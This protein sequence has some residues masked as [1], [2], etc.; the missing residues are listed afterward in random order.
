MRIVKFL[1]TTVIA[2]YG[3]FLIG[4]IVIP[5]EWTVSRSRLIH[6]KP[7]QIYPFVSDFKEWEQWSS[8]NAKKDPSLKYTYS[9]PATGI[10]SRQSW[11]SQKMGKG[12]MVITEANPQTGVA[13]TLFID[14]G[15]SQSTL[16]GRIHF[17][18]Q[19]QATLVEWTDQG[20]SENSFVKR[21]MSLMIKPM[22]GKEFETGLTHLSALVYA[23][24]DHPR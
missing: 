22:L 6:A 16:H 11:T 19:E 17:T 21:W 8:W 12:W 18:Q 7:E 1:L 13:Y 2:L 23:H 10:G 4:G 15:Y 3:I 14:M 5:D 20:H 24:A 9:G